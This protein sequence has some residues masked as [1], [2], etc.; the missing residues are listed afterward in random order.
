MPPIVPNPDA[1]HSFTSEAAF[2]RWLAKH[3]GTAT[4][5]WI[6]VHKKAS[7]LPTISTG[8]ALDVAL[9]WGWIDAIRKSF[10]NS[11]FLQRYTPRQ[12]RSIW[13][14]INTHHVARLINAGRMQPPGHA[15]IDAAKADGR[16]DMAYSGSKTMQAPADL[17]AAIEANAKAHALYQQLS[18]QNRYALSFRVGNLKTEVAR[19]KRIQTFVNMLARGETIYPNKSTAVL[20]AVGKASKAASKTRRRT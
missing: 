15:Q 8:E 12:K 2:E 20:R 10:D 13:S 1:I 18:S 7:G 19:A 4:E 3:H 17:L 6:K 14:L 9:C 11:S 5:V 16:W